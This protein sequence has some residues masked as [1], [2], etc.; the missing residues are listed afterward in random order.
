MFL[1]FAIW[2]KVS[3]NL[4]ISA[5]TSSSSAVKLWLDPTPGWETQVKLA[6]LGSILLLIVLVPAA[7][8][9]VPRPLHAVP[10][11]RVAAKG[12]F[13]ELRLWFRPPPLF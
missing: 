3:P 12:V 8:L 5:S 13:C 9:P 11:P 4:G 2:L 1:C 6:P 7:L 10:A